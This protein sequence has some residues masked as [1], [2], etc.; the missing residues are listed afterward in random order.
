M[1]TIG[2]DIRRKILEIN[3]TGIFLTITD[4]AG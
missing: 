2:T 4:T 1:A 3:Q